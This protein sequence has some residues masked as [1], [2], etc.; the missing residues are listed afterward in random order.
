M[1]MKKISSWLL[2]A[3]TVG[4]LTGCAGMSTSVYESTP[5]HSDA[6]AESSTD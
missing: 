5:V 3:V 1:T 2:V 4:V 6:V